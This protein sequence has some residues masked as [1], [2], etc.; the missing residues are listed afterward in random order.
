MGEQWFREAARWR[1]RSLVAR[2]GQT[3]GTI[4]AVF[5]GRSGQTAWV[6]VHTGFFGIRATVV[7]VVGAIV[8][9]EDIRVP[10]RKSFV[11]KAPNIEPAPRLTRDQSERLCDYYGAPAADDP[12]GDCAPT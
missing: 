4:A 11:S 12:P 2:D 9:G 8:D 10:Y 3:I 1:S 6:L 5:P 7:P